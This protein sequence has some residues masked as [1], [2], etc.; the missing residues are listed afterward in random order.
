MNGIQY[1]YDA[2]R[3]L[4][5]KGCLYLKYDA[6]NWLV[7][8]NQ[9]SQYVA[10]MAYDGDGKRVKRVDAYGTVHYVGPHYERNVGNGHQAL[11]GPD[12]ALP[13]A[14]RGA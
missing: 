11:L 9:G 1:V 13:A 10:R 6:E 7:K 2:N 4:T 12:G 5:Q 3:N 8:V 14:D